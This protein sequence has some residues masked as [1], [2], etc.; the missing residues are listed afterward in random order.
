[1]ALNETLAA[2]VRKCV[3]AENGVVEKRMFGG[4]AFLVRGHMSVGVHGNELI[5]R[6]EPSQTERALKQLGV[7]I[8][9]I[10]GRP[11]KGWLLV[12]SGALEQERDLREWVG[13]GLAFARSLPPKVA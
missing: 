12:S 6:I 13:R 7:R 4:L 10:T 8:F 3:A 9:D 2:R 5:V 11:M 1:L